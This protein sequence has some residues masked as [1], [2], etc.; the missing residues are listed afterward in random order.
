MRE[1]ELKNQM[2]Q[3]RNETGNSFEKNRD[4]AILHELQIHTKLAAD[5]GNNWLLSSLQKLT[6]VKPNCPNKYNEKMLE[7]SI[8]IFRCSPKAY[9]MLKDCGLTLPSVSTIGRYMRLVSSQ[10][11]LHHEILYALAEVCNSID[12][13]DRCV[14]IGFDEMAIAPSMH[15]DEHRD[16]VIGGVDFGPYWEHKYEGRMADKVLFVL[17]RS[18]S[19]PLVQA[20]GH[21]FGKGEVPGV[22]LKKNQQ[23]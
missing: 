23:K 6:T 8:T 21:Y 10:C 19:G 12:P 1:K 7:F 14:M 4:C 2:K 17:M 5:L 16:T 13:R 18:C 20:I 22:I 11:G 15:Y 3:L 9:R